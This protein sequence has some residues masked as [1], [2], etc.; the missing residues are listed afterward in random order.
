MLKGK[1]KWFDAKKGYGFIHGEDGKDIFVHHTAI[2]SQEG[3]KTLEEGQDVTFEVI[4]EDKGPKA[5][6]VKV[7]E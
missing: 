7:A 5:A 4:Q 3:F 2:T 1:V 6:N